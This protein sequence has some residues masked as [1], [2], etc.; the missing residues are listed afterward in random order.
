VRNRTGIVISL[1]LAA[2]LAAQAGVAA[3]ADPNMAGGS[4]VTVSGRVLPPPPD[5]QAPSVHA[6]MLTANGETQIAFEPG[7][8]PSVQLSVTD[9]G[10]TSA[11]N[12]IGSTVEPGTTQALPNGLRKEVFGFL[13]YWMLTD[14]ALA[15]LRYGLVSSIAYFSVG[16]NKDGYLLKGSSASPTTGW[17]GWT[18][19]RMTNVINRA[20]GYGVKVV[21]TV[22]MM[23]WDSSSAANM[24]SFLGSSTSRARLVTQVVDAVRSRGA[25]GVN[26][27]FE[28]VAAS[29][30]ANYTAFVRQLKKGLTD[31]GVGSYLTV[32]VTAGAATWSTGYDVAGL[33]A[34]GGANHLF[35][36]GYDYNWS[37]S[38]RAGGVA[39]IRSPYTIDVSGTMNDF[40][41]E[42]AG[43][44]VIWGVPYYGREWPTTSSQL[45]ATT[46]GGASSAYY[47]TGHKSRA[48]KHGRLWDDTGKVPWY[49][50]QSSGQWVQGYYDDVQSLGVKYDLVNARGFAGTGMWTLLM[51]QGTNDLW[52]LVAGK[53]VTDTAP[54]V[55]G[56]ELMPASTDSEAV[57]V[58]WNV[59]D[60]ASGVD[61]YNVQVRRD[62]GS[63]GTWLSNTHATDS[64]YPAVAGST[65]AF[66]VQAIDA[67]GNAQPWL[68][69]PAT[70]ASLTT[71]AFATISTNSLNVRSGAGTAFASVASLPR[72]SVVYVLDGPV[73][74][75]GY[76]WYRIQHS[77]AEWPSSDYAQIGWAAAGSG[78]ESYMVPAQ[79]PTSTGVD[80]FV[81]GLAAPHAITPGTDGQDDTAL[82]SFTLRAASSQ[83]SV[84]ILREDGSVARSWSLG[85]RG[86]GP[87]TATWNGRLQDGSPA[88]LGTYLPRVTATDGS[89][90]DHVAPGPVYHPDLIARWGIA[91]YPEGMAIY[92]PPVQLAFAEGTHTGYRFDSAGKP[93]ASKTYTLGHASGAPAGLRGTLPGQSG[94]WY[95]VTAGVWSGY[96]LRESPGLFLAGSPPPPSPGS[97]LTFSPAV[98][99]NVLAGTHTGYRF[100]SAGRPIASR[101]YT[102]GSNSGASTSALRAVANQHGRWLY[103]VNG[104]WAGYW[105]P[106]TEVVYLVGG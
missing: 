78:G 100:D 11:D 73:A 70:P 42:T 19:S 6:E 37:G 17:A 8:K 49:R 58:A 7:Q 81:S 64:W 55:G 27:D 89:G 80:P 95:Y 96:W 36:M 65:Y 48:A 38:S 16:A 97:D 50:Y 3:G 67:R 83:V 56:I 84:A 35:V 87:S 25:D 79:A 34:S 44:K 5:P 77:F 51:D 62:N 31:A 98:R 94:T 9:G 90:V 22:T 45:N 72:N 43:S 82:I 26:L 24:A 52:S 75:N 1:V 53:F 88:P 2:M 63:W 93:T 71:Q 74:A 12:A 28:P 46:T 86:S 92:D 20:H 69:V 105:L 102:L 10:E 91:A 33:T 21:L 76:Q 59:I 103:V 60:L 4:V 32:C 13:P 18:S 101:T 99:F 54:P 29:Q 106:A 23:A 30:R 104:V 41:A 39:P 40:L 85:S 14:A 15:E 68:P 61:R 66:R 47:Y 57:H